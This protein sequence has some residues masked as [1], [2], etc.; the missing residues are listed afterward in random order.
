MTA[1]FTFPGQGSQTVGMGKALA[2]TFFEA[3]EATPRRWGDGFT[4]SSDQIWHM[5][6]GLG[7]LAPPFH[8]GHLRHRKDAADF[9]GHCYLVLFEC[10][11]LGQA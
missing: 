10:V 5:L 2:D 7:H 9:Y 3:R 11:S 8:V 6:F 1:A 4:L